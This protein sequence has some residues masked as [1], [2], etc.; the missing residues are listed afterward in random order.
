MTAAL[1][2]ARIHALMNAL[3]FASLDEVAPGTS[4]ILAPHPD[5]ESLGCGG[6]IA[7]LCQAGRPPLVV[8]ATDGAASHPGSAEYPPAKLQA[9]RE[10]EMLAACA[11]L[12]VPRSRVHFLGMPDG[13][14]PTRGPAF[15]AAARTIAGLI[16]THAIH[17]IFATWPHDPH[18]DH[19]AVAGLAAAAAAA[20]ACGARLMFYPVWGWLLRPGHQLPAN[21]ARGRRVD[22]AKC[23]PLKRRAIAAHA[24]QY[25]GL[26]TDSPDG[27]VLPQALLSVFDRPFEV[28]LDP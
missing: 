19:Q 10:A 14:A 18:C 28:F 16:K 12:G 26:I 21:A 17:T 9:L 11:I 5:D 22:I 24:S 7:A 3:P 20:E 4:L 23:L 2:I 1:P 8:C 27:F 13:Q 25:H 15:D 6:L